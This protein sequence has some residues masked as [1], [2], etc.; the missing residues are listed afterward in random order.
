[1]KCRELQY[2]LEDYEKVINNLEDNE[3]MYAIVYQDLH[4]T[5]SSIANQLFKEVADILDGLE[6]EEILAFCTDYPY[7]LEG[8]GYDYR[9]GVDEFWDLFHDY[10]NS[11]L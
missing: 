3:D 9:N 1:M 8:T 4:E 11:R 2:S 6:K 5:G 10:L 7:R